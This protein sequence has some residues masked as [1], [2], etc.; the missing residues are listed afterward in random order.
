MENFSGDAQFISS[1]EEVASY[2]KQ[3]EKK[4]VRWFFTENPMFGGIRPIE[5]IILGKQKKL[6]NW[7]LDQKYGRKK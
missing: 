6:L 4:T 3:N 2:F 5:M 1:Y 7:I